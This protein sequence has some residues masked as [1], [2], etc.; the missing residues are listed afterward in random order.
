MKK[1]SLTPL[2][3]AL[4]A[5]VAQA[6]APDEA[7]PEQRVKREAGERFA[8]RHPVR[9]KMALE[10][11]DELKAEGFACWMEWRRALPE[12]DGVK[13]WIHARYGMMYCSRWNPRPG[14]PCIEERVAF[15]VDWHNPKAEGEALVAQLPTSPVVGHS[16]V[17]VPSRPTPAS[18]DQEPISRSSSGATD[19]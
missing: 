14:V 12:V 9:G 4:G 3:F 11:I 13:S 10:V 16:H 2:I 8:S 17:C 6:Q 18:S 5:C 1:W 19:K 7:T 15:D